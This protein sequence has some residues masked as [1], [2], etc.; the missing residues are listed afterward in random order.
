M[1]KQVL[2]AINKVENVYCELEDNKKYYAIQIGNPADEDFEIEV[3]KTKT[4]EEID[5]I[6]N[7]CEAFDP[8][9]H[10]ALWFGANRGEPSSVQALL[11]NCNAIADTLDELADALRNFKM[12]VLLWKKEELKKN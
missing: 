9:E 12:E 2:N 1:N 5:F 7:F 3:P 10:F 8:E 6:I 11:D 4:S